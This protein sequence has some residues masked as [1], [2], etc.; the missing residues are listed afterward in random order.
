MPQEDE[1]QGPL[2]HEDMGE[3]H[4]YMHEGSTTDIRPSQRDTARSH[5]AMET[6]ERRWNEHSHRDAKIDEFMRRREGKG[7]TTPGAAPPVSQSQQQLMTMA[8]LE[9]LL[10]YQH[11][12]NY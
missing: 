8:D 7:R 10:A 4:D 1:P 9:E 2:P 6:G 11:D 12:P 5:Q 3:G